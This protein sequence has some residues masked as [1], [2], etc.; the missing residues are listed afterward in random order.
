VW[1]SS[2][3]GYNKTNGDSVAGTTNVTAR[4]YGF[5]A[6]MVYHFTPGTFAGFALAGSGSN[7]GLAQGL[8][9]G[10]SDSFQIGL[11][12][13]TSSGATYLAASLA[14]ANHWMTTDRFAPLG[15]RLTANF[16]AQGYGARLEGG[17]RYAVT[18]TIGVTPYTAL[19]AQ[20]FHTPSYSETDLTGAGF[21]LSYNAATAIDTRSELGARLDDL[22]SVNAVPLRLRASAAW[23]HDWMSNSSLMPTFQ[24]LPGAGFIVNG[25]AV[26][27]NSALASAG[28]ELQLT[29]NWSLT[30]KFDSEFARGSQTSA[31][32]GTLR[33]VW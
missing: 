27:K 33:Y 3:G 23:A 17:Y 32:T 5:A 16:N 13:K 26:P 7:W 14:F 15:D 19:Q 8:G 2:F 21:G 20:N 9:G 28:A 12:G 29:N 30:A 11:Y 6:G 18:P 10:R 1:G 4:A 22:T 25:A 31:G 24:A